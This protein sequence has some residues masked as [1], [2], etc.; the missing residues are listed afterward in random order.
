[1]MLT[2][3]HIINLIKLFIWS[4]DFFHYDSTNITTTAGQE[5]DRIYVAEII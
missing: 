4:N 5:Q 3:I 1:M 2:R